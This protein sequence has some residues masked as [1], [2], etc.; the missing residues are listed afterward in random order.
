MKADRIM[1]IMN[2]EI[3]ED[4]TH[5]DLIHSKGKYHDLWSKQIMVK[6]AKDHSKSR[7]RSPNKKDANILND[8]DPER[9]TTTLKTALQTTHHP[10][11][12][13]EIGTGGSSAKVCHYLYLS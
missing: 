2:G 12:N 10:E 6:S 13:S 4:G 7:G 8:I 11:P 5:E 1:V 9:P 3:V